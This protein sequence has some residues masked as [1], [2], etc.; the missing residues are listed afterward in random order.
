M[1]Y[2]TYRQL[3]PLYQCAAGQRPRDVAVTESDLCASVTP[4]TSSND[5]RAAEDTG[6]D[7]A[8]GI[9]QFC[10]FAEKC[11]EQT[12]A[13]HI[14]VDESSGGGDAAAAGNAGVGAAA[15]KAF[16]CGASG[17]LLSPLAAALAC[18]NGAVTGTSTVGDGLK[19]TVDLCCVT[20]EQSDA[21]LFPHAAADAEGEAATDD[22]GGGPK[23]K[24][25]KDSSARDDDLTGLIAS[26]L[27]TM[28]VFL[29][30][31]AYCCI[32]NGGDDAA[33]PTNAFHSD[34]DSL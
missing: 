3:C 8:T 16:P 30:L 34:N 7:A 15:T 29:T 14:D 28:V 23:T 2:V 19:C 27:I 6:V 13:A 12:C 5:V 4:P 18:N 32:S 33:K 24:E 1:C 26:V 21:L 17:M 22:G 25:E 31:G 9:D 10:S 11:C 20:Q